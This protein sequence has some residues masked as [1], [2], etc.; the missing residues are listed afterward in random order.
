MRPR[1]PI[2]PH[3]PRDEVGSSRGLRRGDESLILGNWEPQSLALAG[4]AVYRT[5]S[6]SD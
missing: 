5:A 4:E 1:T 6:G 2:A 3:K